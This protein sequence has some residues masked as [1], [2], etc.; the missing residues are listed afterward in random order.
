MEKTVKVGTMP[1]K[2]EEYIVAV[3]TSIKAL[4]GIAGKDPTGYEVKVDTFK[5]DDLE[6]TSVEENTNVVLLVK[7][8]KGN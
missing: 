2:I 3:G 1:G 7:Q 6:N 4:L 8:V 5:V